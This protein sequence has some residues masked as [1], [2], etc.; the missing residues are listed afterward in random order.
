MASGD[1]EEPVMVAE[2][3]RLLNFPT[4][5][6]SVY[7]TQA[8]KFSEEL[9]VLLFSLWQEGRRAALRWPF[10][11][12]KE[13]SPNPEEVE[14]HFQRSLAIVFGDKR[15]DL[16][17][18]T[19]AVLFELWKKGRKSQPPMAKIWEPPTRFH[20]NF[21]PQYP[22]PLEEEESTRF[23]IRPLDPFIGGMKPK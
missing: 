3:R 13:P 22:S 6:E 7:G 10:L 14:N 15:Q 17:Q 1:I 16:G 2:P 5:L 11:H 8:S 23:P 18:Q 12:S 4:D 21:E 20:V 9:R 19:E